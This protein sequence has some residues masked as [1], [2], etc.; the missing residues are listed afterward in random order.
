M[1]IKEIENTELQI[2]KVNMNC[3]KCIQ[4]SKGRSIIP[5]LMNTSHFYIISGASGSGKTNLIV[6]LLKSNKQTKDKKHKLSYRKMFNKIVFVSP[7]AD[8]ITNSPIE[9]IADNQK[10]TALDEEVFDYVEEISEDAVDNDNHNLLIL[11][12]VSS[13]LRSKENEKKLNQIIKN[14]RHKNLSVWIIGH[15]LIDFQPSLRTNANMIF[16]FNPK[17]NKELETIQSEYFLM[18]RKEANEIMNSVYKTRYDFMIIDTSL[19]TGST[20]RFFRNFNELLFED[21][22]KNENVK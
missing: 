21:E 2:N 9:K 14:R 4:D 22:D 11:D 6:N 7:S 16:I 20:F 19:R 3:D 1:K 15:R 10:F 18:P 13:Q 8:T 5:P 12:D 17:T